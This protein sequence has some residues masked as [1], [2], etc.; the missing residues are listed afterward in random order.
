MARTDALRPRNVTATQDEKDALLDAAPPYLRLWI[1]FCSDLAIRSGTAA[2]L[3][4]EHYDPDSGI[5]HFTTKKGARQTLP[6][7][8]EIRELLA[9][10]DQRDPSAFV[11]QLKRN[12]RRRGPLPPAG[13]A[14]TSRLNCQFA[15]LR[16]SLGI[17]R[18][19]TLHDLRRTTAVAMLQHTHDIRDVQALLGHRSLQSTIW[20]LDHDLRPVKRNHLEL[21]KRQPAAESERT[22]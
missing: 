11:Q 13:P 15:A 22:A 6:V 10:C 8:H 5:L 21:I 4:P 19:L 18:K 9:L 17:T 2:R 3:S 1:L 20:Y 16:R 12:Q 14:N 7:T